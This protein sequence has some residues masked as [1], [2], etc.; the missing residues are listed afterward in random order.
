MATC[1]FKIC[2]ANAFWIA[3]SNLRKAVREGS[4]GID[5]LVNLVEGHAKYGIQPGVRARAE[6]L[7]WERRRSTKAG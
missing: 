1:E 6:S 3:S 7:L 2:E 5:V 4:D